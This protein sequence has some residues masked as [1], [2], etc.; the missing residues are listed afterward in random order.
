MDDDVC[1][2]IEGGELSDLVRLVSTVAHQLTKT[3]VVCG[4]V[5]AAL[6][7]AGD[8]YMSV[9]RIVLECVELFLVTNRKEALQ[10]SLQ[11]V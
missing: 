7:I 9:F 4:S 8:S 10:F 2:K 11:H 3:C 5:S 1:P 6:C